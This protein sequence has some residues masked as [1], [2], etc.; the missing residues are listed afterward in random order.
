MYEC[1]S[2]INSIHVHVHVHDGVTRC[3]VYV[4]FADGSVDA[5]RSIVTDLVGQMDPGGKLHSHLHIC[6]CMSVCIIT[7]MY[8]NYSKITF[9]SS[10]LLTI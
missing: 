5:E 2:V 4:Y 3:Y 10:L 6:V 9:T 7:Y 8:M 1:V